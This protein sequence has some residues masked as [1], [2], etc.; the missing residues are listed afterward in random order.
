MNGVL[1]S[2]VAI[3]MLVAGKVTLV[4]KVPPLVTVTFPAALLV[5]QFTPAALVEFP[6]SSRVWVV[7][8]LVRDR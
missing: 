3:E 2:A 4:G 8:L 7:T 5:N 1:L 6:A